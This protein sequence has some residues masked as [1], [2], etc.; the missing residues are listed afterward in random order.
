MRLDLT[1]KAAA[2]R[3]GVTRR[4]WQRWEY[5][6]ALPDTPEL[7]RLAARLGTSVAAL[8]GENGAAPTALEPSNGYLEDLVRD[9]VRRALRGAR[10]VVELRFDD[11]A[12]G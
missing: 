1:Q 7:N 5:G 4:T 11:K 10:I 9:E 12:A 2:K 8:L 6:L 3:F